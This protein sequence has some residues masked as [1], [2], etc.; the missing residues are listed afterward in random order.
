MVLDRVHHEARIERLEYVGGAQLD[1]LLVFGRHEPH[2]KVIRAK[3]C[4]LLH[5]CRGHKD[6]SE[7][8]AAEYVSHEL[9]PASLSSNSGSAIANSTT[10]PP[11]TLFTPS[12][13]S[14]DP[15]IFHWVATSATDRTVRFWD[16]TRNYAPMPHTLYTEQA[17]V[18]LRWYPQKQVLYTADDNRYALEEVSRVCL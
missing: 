8:L 2:F 17:Q 4:A 6:K 15:S 16:V 14:T 9:T 7:L 3:D 5:V 1:H 12:T 11:S 13:S 10:K 18:A